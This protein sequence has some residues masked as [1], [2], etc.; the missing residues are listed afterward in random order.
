MGTGSQQERER[1]TIASVTDRAVVDP[2]V[3]HF[4]RLGRILPIPL[5]A[6]S[7][8]LAAIA[9]SGGY[10]SSARFE[11][12]LIVVALAAAWS[13]AV[14]DRLRPSTS[15]GRRLAAFGVHTVLAGVLVWVNPWYGVFAVAGY[16]LAD[17]LGL[18][19]RKA[20][21]AVTALLLAASQ[22]GGYPSGPST[23]TL[24][25]LLMA[26]VNLALVLSMASLTNRVLQQN[27]ERGRMIDDL[28][29]A[30]R[31]LEATMAENAD[32]HAELVSQAREAGIVDERQRLAGE[33]H[34]TLAQGLAGIVAQL[35]AAEQARHHPGEWTRHLVQA[36]SLAR[37]RRTEA[38]RSVRALRPEQL[39][40]ASLSAAISCLTRT[41]SEQSLVRTEVDTTGSPLRAGVA[42]EAAVFRVAQEALSNVA[43][44]ARASKV[45]VT[46]TYLDDAVLLDVA[47]DGDGFD[48]ATRQ[49]GYGLTGMQQRL[50]RVSG[51]LTVES[52]PGY[53]T[54]INASVPLRA[55]R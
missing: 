16:I 44:H 17:D 28:G 13:V 34:D 42:T 19:W 12:G 15:A 7:T 36:K 11:Y 52:A 20:G 37:S 18:R 46:L 29:E 27:S 6:T 2:W 5:L 48:P 32:L 35:E 43:K 39:E 24:T 40:D 53:G 8:A 25:Y 23:H 55:V 51:T 54:T 50:E 22:T 49:D 30:N 1:G 33:I 47:D 10:K 9:V 38:R 31:R 45:H 3:A 4:D 41:W 14:S 26:G 21:F